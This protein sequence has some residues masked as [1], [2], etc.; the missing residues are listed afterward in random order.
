MWPF[1][2][3]AAVEIPLLSKINQHILNPLISFLIAL[4]IVT[5]LYGAWESLRGGDEERAQGKTHMLWG[6]VGIFIMVSAI[7]I[8]NVICRTIGC[9]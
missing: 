6:V 8:L 3:L 2:A 7:G 5:F 1:A 9:N 4:A